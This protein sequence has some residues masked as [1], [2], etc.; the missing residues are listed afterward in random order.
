[1]NIGLQD[2]GLTGQLPAAYANLQGVTAIDISNN[3]LEGDLSVFNAY[4]N[5]ICKYSKVS[6]FVLL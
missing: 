6:D 3:E 1:M 2:S 4:K 5:L